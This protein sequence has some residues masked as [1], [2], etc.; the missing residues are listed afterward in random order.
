MNE[1]L[2]YKI[3]DSHIEVEV[4]FENETVWLNQKQLSLLF[5]K[6]ITTINEH[7]KNIYSEK[8]LEEF[9][10]IRKS[11]IVQIEGNRKVERELVFYN[12]DVIISVG[13]RVKSIQGTQFRQWATKRLN[14]YLIDGVSLNKKRLEQLQQTIKMISS[15]S[16][17]DVN[18]HEAK[19]LLEIINQYTQSF[20]LL[21]DFD[22]NNLKEEKLE[23]EISYEIEYKEAVEAIDILK[24]ELI[25]KNQATSLFGNQKDQSFEGTLMN[26]VQTFD[27]NYLYQTIEEQAA[28][29]L[30][31]IIKNHPFSDGNK[32][33]GAFLFIWYLDKNKHRFKKSGELKINDNGLTTLALLVA[34]SNPSDKD[35]MIKLIVNLINER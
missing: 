22:S 30:Y 34:Q 11:R 23:H 5:D 2:I 6:G 8:E 27:G 13:Y 12:L 35:L 15:S 10:T 21:N 3:G 25:S 28:N 17:E 29:L 7:I 20:S 14:E 33:I 19:G 1:I 31:L 32:R 4:A 26:V 9:S 24:N 18:L 16:L